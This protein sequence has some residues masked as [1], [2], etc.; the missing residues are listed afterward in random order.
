MRRK[1]TAEA[2]SWLKSQHAIDVRTVRVLSIN[3]RAG[4][5]RVR[6]H[7]REWTIGLGCLI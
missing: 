2:R 1:L 5:A 3:R 7:S 6:W 4:T